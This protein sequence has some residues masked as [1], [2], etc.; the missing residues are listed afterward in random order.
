[1]PPIHVRLT[2]VLPELAQELREGLVR[3][4]WPDLVDQVDEL[5]IYEPCVCGDGSCVGFR[6]EPRRSGTVVR[7]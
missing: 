6:T 2:Y 5:V 1:M 3:D 4:G 7:R